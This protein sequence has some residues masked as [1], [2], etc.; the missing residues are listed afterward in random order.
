MFKLKGPKLNVHSWQDLVDGRGSLDARRQ[1]L[2]VGAVSLYPMHSSGI[3][4][5]LYWENQKNKEL[6][7]HEEK[8]SEERSGKQESNAAQKPWRN[9]GDEK[10]FRQSIEKNKEK[11]VVLIKRSKLA[12]NGM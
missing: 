5:R 7:K 12:A 10:K 9:V 3:W 1:I 11:R 8:K 4:E 2:F 6:W